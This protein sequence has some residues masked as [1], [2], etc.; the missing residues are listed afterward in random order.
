MLFF[1]NCILAAIMTERETYYSVLKKYWGYDSFRPLQE[2]IVISALAGNDTLALM[3]TGGGKSITFQVPALTREGI[4]IVVTP[5]IALMRDQVENLKKRGVRALCVYS[6]MSQSEIDVTLENCIYGDFKFLYCSPERLGTEIF[7]QRVQKMNVNFLVV[8]E[9]HCI[10]Q[11][12][13]DFRPSYLKIADF[14]ELLPDVPVLALTAT[15]TPE[16]VTDIQKILGFKKP[17]LL[18]MSF[19]RSNLSYLVRN[20][21]DK[22]QA[23]LKVIQ[24]VPG[25][26]VVYVRNRHKTKE[27]A[28]FLQK[29]GFSADY[30]HAGLTNAERSEKQND[31]KNGKTRIIVST[32]AFGMGIDKA[33]VRFVVHLD[34]PDTIEAYFQ[35]AGRGG[36]DEKPAF[37]VLLYHE[38]DKRNLEQRLSVNFPEY[39]MIRNVYQ[40]VGNFLKVPYGAG[41]GIAFDF[42]LNDFVSA[43]RFNVMEAYNSLKILEQYGYLELTDELD[44]SA[45]VMFLVNRD[46]LYRFQVA[47]ESLDKLI[48][49]ILRTY[50]GT[51]DQYTVIDENVLAKNSGL[52]QQQV[53]QGLVQLS[54]SKIL[55]FIP[56]KKTPLLI[57]CEERLD[58]KNLRLPRESYQKKKELY[59]ERLNAVLEYAS[60]TD[61]CR[62][63]LLL[64]YFGE[65]LA[66]DCEKCDVCR[67]RRAN[68]KSDSDDALI[69]NVLKHLQ[70]GILTSRQLTEA[71]PSVADEIVVE[72]LRW[73][74]DN[75]YVLDLPEG[76]KLS[77]KKYSSM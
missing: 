9:A 1:E 18:K 71:M 64:R 77:G 5:L 69:N 33:D 55:H 45:K 68:Y 48:K 7:R 54:K 6:G 4:C 44:H 52:T 37:A 72:T 60:S 61:V 8:D 53:Y 20:V 50:T 26:G 35:E 67:Q 40:A 73:L 25:T 75:G 74:V 63:R 31:W 28:V 23:L 43:Y 17:N 27:I 29:E 39:E 3:P 12:G 66:T 58:D 16:V 24:N 21:E 42:K 65:D 59:T 19:S 14:R 62:S 41:K 46:D 10:S 34:L 36:R 76:Y 57:W 49:I 47:N 11:W 13:Y 15:A 2:D 56:R 22:P 70:S 32:N 30:Y 38:S 51:F